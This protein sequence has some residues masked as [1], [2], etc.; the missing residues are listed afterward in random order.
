MDDAVTEING[1]KSERSQALCSVARMS[2][3]WMRAAVVKHFHEGSHFWSE[4]AGE[5]SRR[6][7]TLGVR[8]QVRAILACTAKQDPQSFCQ[9][10]SKASESNDEYDLLRCWITPRENETP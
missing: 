9:S 1:G 8:S 10:T 2:Y 6:T 5:I 7:W 4:V 3:G